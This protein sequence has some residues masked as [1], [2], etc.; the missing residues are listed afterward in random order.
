MA[1]GV[2]ILLCSVVIVLFIFILCIFLNL[3]KLARRGEMMV[4]A[5]L[6]IGGVSKEDPVQDVVGE[7]TMTRQG[8]REVLSD[9]KEWLDE[10]D[11]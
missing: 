2:G 9:I 8:A 1:R 11:S 3:A 5:T 6:K 10:V 7:L 4:E